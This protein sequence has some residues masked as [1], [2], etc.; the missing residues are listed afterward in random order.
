MAELTVNN[1]TVVAEREAQLAGLIKDALA[2]F[3]PNV[4]RML[5]GRLQD[6][7]L[8]G[9][10]GVRQILGGYDLEFFAKAYFPEYFKHPTPQFHKEAYAEIS[11]ILNAQPSR[12]RLVRAWPRSNAK[13]TIYN[14]FMPLNAALYGKR[15]FLVQVSDSESQAEGFL[16]DVKNAIEN[17]DALREDFGDTQGL[18]WRVDMISVRA[19][20]GD[21]VWVAAV[22]AGSSI[23]GLKKAE[24][25]PDLITVDDLESDSS[26]ATADRIGKMWLWFNRALLNLGD[27][28]TDIVVVGTVLANDCVLD[29]LLKSPTWDA[30]RLAAVIKWSESPLWDEWTKLYT[31]LSVA[32][33]TRE[34]NAD[35]FFAAHREEMLAGTE[36]LWPEG[37][38]YDA[39]MKVY[40]DVGETAFYSEHQNDP[41]NLEECLVKPDWLVYY[42]EDELDRV[43]ITGYYGALDPSLGKTRLS[44]YTA[45]I[46]IGRGDN[47]F[48][49]VV[50]AVVERLHPDKIVELLL[51][52]GREYEFVRFG[53]ETHQFQDLLRMM[54]IERG[55]REGLY[56]PLVE[57]KQTK[58]KVMRIQA[59]LP[60]IKN[61]YIR[62][63]RAHRLL[64]EQLLGFPKVRHDD[65]P[66]CL[67]MAVRMVSHGPSMEPLL[68]GTTPEGEL[69]DS[70]EDE[71]D[72]GFMSRCFYS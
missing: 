58:D 31:D 27:E 17:N 25:R 22:G 49:Y 45:L 52:A 70:E 56:L 66:D 14:F 40:V 50:E 67:E 68:A 1:P 51:E 5:L 41:V 47:G 12:A 43:R 6:C 4:R 34:V 19:I 7:P 60:Y 18:V 29:R 38:P 64:I 30:R 46:V 71:D 24:N 65:A 55:A 26:V 10:G 57:I 32:K 9:S 39:L 16:A 61:G 3:P 53:I 63:N 13:S 59:L 44:D 21:V 37:K 62:F 69:R 48:L 33:E 42:D 54:V 8:T 11:R 15:R 28:N 2:K 23:R 72:Y 20:T 36:V 35:K